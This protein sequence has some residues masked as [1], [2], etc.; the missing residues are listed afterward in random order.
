M[1]SGAPALPGWRRQQ[2]KACSKG[3]TP[4]WP[5]A[6]TQPSL[7][8]IRIPCSAARSAPSKLR[9][10]L[11]TPSRTH[12]QFRQSQ[13]PRGLAAAWSAV[14]GAAAPLAP[15]AGWPGCDAP[16]AA[17]AASC[18][19]ASS[20]AAVDAKRPLSWDKSLVDKLAA[21]AVAASCSPIC[22]ARNS[23]APGS[24]SLAALSAVT[25]SLAE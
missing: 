11:W 23:I 12:L 10:H 18:S 13:P 4:P 19:A 17:V 8:R 25:A 1:V 15:A 6:K 21:P 2:S 7:P 14:E 5:G 24:C 3:P 9:F 22:R 16:A 20:A